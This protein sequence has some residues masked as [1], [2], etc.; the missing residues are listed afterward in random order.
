MS[1]KDKNMLRF[2]LNNTIRYLIA[3]DFIL[4]AAW[5]FIEPI[6]AIFITKKI[7][8]GSA[9]MVGIAAAIYWIS[10]SI[11]QI[12]IAHV[13]DKNPGEQDDYRAI[14][15]GQIIVGIASLLF[16]SITKPLH[17]YI[18]QFIAALGFALIIPA[19]G[20]IFTRHIDKGKEGTEWA[21]DSTILGIAAGITGF[22]GGIIAEV[23]GFQLVFTIVAFMSFLSIIFP[24][25]A[26]HATTKRYHKKAQLK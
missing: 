26:S 23:F 3:S 12:P 10:K 5:G 19:W 1:S 17:L 15:L 4:F 13:L 22:L 20:A 6:F 16:I 14:I 11:L 21:L 9:A 7:P 24:F 8:G 2:S 18:V 25:L